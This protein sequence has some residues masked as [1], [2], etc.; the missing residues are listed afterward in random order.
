MPRAKAR[1]NNAR[2]RPSLLAVFGLLGLTTLPAG[3]LNFMQP[4][5]RAAGAF[6]VNSRGD[7]A[8]SNTADGVCNDGAGKLYSTSRAR[9]G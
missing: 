1:R 5:A 2:T 7:G 9:A 4:A 6:T 3:V 8:D